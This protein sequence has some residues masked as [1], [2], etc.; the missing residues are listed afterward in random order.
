MRPR[1]AAR[2]G[3]GRRGAVGD[4]RV[5]DRRACAAWS[6]RAPRAFARLEL[7]RIMHFRTGVLIVT[8]H[9]DA[10]ACSSAFADQRRIVA[11]DEGRCCGRE[12]FKRRPLAAPALPSTP[13]CPFGVSLRWFS[14]KWCSCPYFAH[15]MR[16]FAQSAYRGE[17]Q[18]HRRK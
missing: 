13:G 7:E 10:P 11:G 4:V 2:F 5:S 12:V 6:G 16:E 9:R 17:H 15:G 18:P 14:G 3:G 8:M 1:V